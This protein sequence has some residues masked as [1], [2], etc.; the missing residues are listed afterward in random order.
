MDI[1]KL[2]EEIG[3]RKQNLNE[4]QNVLGEKV[5]VKQS[6]DQFLKELMHSANTG[7]PTNAS[8]K[9]KAVDKVAE[10]KITGKPVDPNIL[11]HVASSAPSPNINENVATQPQRTAAMDAKMAEAK[12]IREMANNPN[13][14]IPQTS[15]VGVADAV[16]QYMNTPQVGAPMQNNSMLTEQQ[17][18]AQFG[19]KAGATSAP[20]QLIAEQVNTVA[21]QLLN[22]NFGKLY[23]EAM[24][25]SI[26]ETYKA[27]V[28]KEAI[29]EN[30]GF[31]EQIV[32]ETIIDLQKKAQSRK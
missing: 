18:L 2:R 16:A 28:I 10:S 20:N 23:A 7:Q 3:Q 32:R 14:G 11:D 8:V 17:M 4:R 6:G 13:A 25:N 19:T 29:N 30:R 12:R 15:N 9:V 27:E 21:T 26:I 24:K 22:E 31:I 1:D 5:S